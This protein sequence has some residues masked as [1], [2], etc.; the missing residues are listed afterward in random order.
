MLPPVALRGPEDLLAVLH[1]VAVSTAPGE[2]LGQN[3]VVD[4]GRALFV[5]Q[6]A[7]LAGLRVH[8]DHAVNLV[9]ALIVF[10][11]ETA[12]ILPPDR[13]STRLNSSHLGISYAVFCLK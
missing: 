5:D 1:V 9:A 10:E 3:V 6:G 11:C 8:F 12:P 13:K 7:R 4:E 2:A